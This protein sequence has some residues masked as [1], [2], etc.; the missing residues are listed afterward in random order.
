MPPSPPSMK[1][2]PSPLLCATDFTP[3]AAAAA[4]VA[5]RL[6]VALQRPLRLVHAAAAISADVL[7]PAQRRLQREALRLREAGAA[8]EPL[9]LREFPAGDAVLR[10]IGVQPPALVVLATAGKSTLDRWRFGSV[11]ERVAQASP[12]PTLV[13]RRA[14][15]LERWLAGGPPLRV[16]VGLDLLASSDAVLRW[17]QELRRAGPCAIIACHCNPRRP[18]AGARTTVNPPAEQ[19]RLERAVR[20]KVRDQLGDEEDFQ[21]VVR[22]DSGAPSVVLPGLLYQENADL[23]VV[24]SH[25]RHGVSRLFHGSLSRAVLRGAQTNVVCVPVAAAFDPR[26]AHVPEYRRVLV[27]TDFSELGN[28]AI[29]HA[30][31]A[32]SIGGLV[33]IVHVVPPPRKRGA[34]T[35]GRAEMERAL[36]R[37]IPAEMGARGQPPE[38]VI[39]EDP[40]PAFALCAE[41][42]RFGADLVCLSSHGMSASRDVFGSVAEAVLKRIRRPLLVVRRPDE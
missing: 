20:K 22:P 7:A 37:L 21:V 29:P 15:P 11:F 25:Q 32:C 31:A 38:V 26:D 9:L 4:L 39:V 33:R 1:T 23:V 6:A 24:G 35:G 13:V 28:A 14:A 12:V 3:G 30:C 16:A 34:Q 8:V 36:R 5:A 42:E 17:L 10:L 19:A 27:A 18:E 2:T 41:A 40:D